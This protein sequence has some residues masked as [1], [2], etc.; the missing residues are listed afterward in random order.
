MNYEYAV[1]FP[2]GLCSAV[3]V[4]TAS[5]TTAPRIYIY[6]FY[7]T[8]KVDDDIELKKKAIMKLQAFHTT[9]GEDSQIYSETEEVDNFGLFERSPEE[10]EAGPNAS[11]CSWNSGNFARKTRK[12]S[13]ASRDC[14][15]APA[16]H[17]RADR[18]ARR[19]HS[20]VHSQQAP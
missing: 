16:R 7:P 9:L 15:Y 6:N 19:G 18:E 17:G 12:N 5:S 4:L 20:C 3:A 10:D 1:E 2:P 14:R 13:V 8:A 11:R